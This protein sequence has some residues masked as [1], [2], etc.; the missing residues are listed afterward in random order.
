MR[1]FP[2]NV[3][4]LDCA[5]FYWR[6]FDRLDGDLQKRRRDAEARAAL[7]NL[8][9]IVFRGRIT[10]TRDL[11]GVGKSNTAFFLIAFKDVEVLRGE[12][13]RSARDGRAFLVASEWCDAKC[14]PA[15]RLWPHGLTT[16]TAHPFNGRLVMDT[17]KNVVYKGRVDAEAGLCDYMQLTPLQTQLL[18]APAD[19][20]ARLIREYPPH[21]IRKDQPADP[22]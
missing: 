20:I 14:G 1:P 8:A 15:S 19:E 21:P 17:D 10:R 2:K 5:H 6:N 13:P 3:N 12:M 11:S 16:F 7:A 18:N 9:P 22:N 4:A